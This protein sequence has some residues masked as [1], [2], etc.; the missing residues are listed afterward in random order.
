VS[1]YTHTGLTVNVKK[2][3]AEQNPEDGAGLYVF[4]VDLDG[5]FVPIGSRKAGSV[6]QRRAK[7]ATSRKAAADA[8]AAADAKAAAD[9]EKQREAQLAADAAAAA[10]GT[11]PPAPGA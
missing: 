11:P 3:D 9:A 8:Q 4:G 7:L 6:D 1:E 5:V 2:I 10:A